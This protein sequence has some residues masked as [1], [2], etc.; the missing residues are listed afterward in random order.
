MGAAQVI[1]KYTVRLPPPTAPTVTESYGGTMFVIDE[2]KEA[3]EAEAR[4]IKVTTLISTSNLI[5]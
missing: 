4:I 1:V 2:M 5:P 3:R